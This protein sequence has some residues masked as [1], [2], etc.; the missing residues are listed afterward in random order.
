MPIAAGDFEGYS[1]A[2]AIR[3]AIAPHKLDLV[4]K[5]PPSL[6]SKP[7]NFLAANPGESV[8]DFVERVAFMRGAFV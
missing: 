4:E 1:A 5:N 3:G 6:W 2:H 7:F 8:L